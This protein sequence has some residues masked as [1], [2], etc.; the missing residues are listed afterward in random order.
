[1][2][3]RRMVALPQ[4]TLAGTEVR[5]LAAP[6]ST[7]FPSLPHGGHVFGAR[8]GLKA[9]AGVGHSGQQ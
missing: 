4:R 3:G 9:P 1:M 5:S 2:R 6:S 7:P 8:P